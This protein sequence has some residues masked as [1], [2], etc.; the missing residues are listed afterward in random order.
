MCPWLFRRS[1]GSSKAARVVFSTVSDPEVAA[2]AAKNRK[3]KT[4]NKKPSKTTEKSTNN[5]SRT[6]S[7]KS[8]CMGGRQMFFL[9]SLSGSSRGISV[10]FLKCWGPPTCT[11][12]FSGSLCGSPAAPNIFFLHPD[13]FLYLPKS[14][15]FAERSIPKK[16]SVH[17]KKSACGDPRHGKIRGDVQQVSNKFAISKLNTASTKDATSS[18]RE[19][20]RL[21][22]RF[23][24]VSPSSLG[25]YFGK[26]T[27]CFVWFVIPI[28][29]R[30]RY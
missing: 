23:N 7:N 2:E 26:I 20:W 24:R 19:A 11:F 10:V 18:K 17:P 13:F 28:S 5:E 8:R 6:S 12:G 14:T 16:P 3:S 4:T 22:A 25:S 21:R 1:K 9:C 27:P 29:H 30:T 15:T